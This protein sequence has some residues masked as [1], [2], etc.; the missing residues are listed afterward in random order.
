MDETLVGQ[1]AGVMSHLNITQYDKITPLLFFSD[2]HL[3]R[4]WY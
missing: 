2:V 1:Q 3:L 4:L